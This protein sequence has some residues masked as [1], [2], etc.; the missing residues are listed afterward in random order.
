MPYDSKAIAN[1]ILNIAQDRGA[2]VS[3]MK[4]HK[5]LYYAHGWHLA[6]QKR[7][8][9]DERIEAWKF[10]PV[11]PSVYHEFKGVGSGVIESRALDVSFLDDGEMKVYEPFI[12]TSHDSSPDEDEFAKRLLER[13]WSLY[14]KY[15]ALQ[16]SDATHKPGTPWDKIHSQYGDVKN[17]DIPDDLIQEYFE[18]LAINPQVL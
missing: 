7:P 9:L 5:L 16:L 13:I 12:A 6:I 14:G 1:E 11:V 8:L 15:T 2:S 3:H 18:S 10:G 17:I 4:L